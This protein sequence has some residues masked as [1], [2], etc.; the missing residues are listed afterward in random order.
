M[1]LRNFAKSCPLCLVLVPRV[2]IS[3]I[4]GTDRDEGL[5]SLAVDLLGTADGVAEVGL[6]L[7]SF[8]RFY[9]SCMYCVYY[10]VQ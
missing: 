6:M 1:D 5:L 2:S 4:L 3:A 8:V 7:L 10:V 9:V